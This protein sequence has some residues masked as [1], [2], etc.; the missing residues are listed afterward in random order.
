LWSQF[1]ARDDVVY[2]DWELTGLRL[3]QWRLLS[4]VLPILP[5]P[6]IEVPS[7]QKSVPKGKPLPIG[8]QSQLALVVTENWLAALTFPPANT[9]TEVTRTSPTELTV[10]RNSQFL[11]TGLELVLLSHWLADAPVGPLDY[12]LLPRAKMTGPGAPRP[13]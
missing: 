5:P 8:K 9:V 12:N 4:E 7:G 1:E 2:Y 13:H 10:A 11:F 6:A 3:L